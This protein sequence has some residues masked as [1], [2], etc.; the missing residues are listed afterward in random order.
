VRRTDRWAAGPRGRPQPGGRGR[1]GIRL[2]DADLNHV[3]LA[4]DSEGVLFDPTYGAKALT[5]VV[6]LVA[7]GERAPIVLWHGGG[8]PAALS[9]LAGSSA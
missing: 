2:T 1:A 3:R 7:A 8:T 9:L 4:L 6:R 5:A